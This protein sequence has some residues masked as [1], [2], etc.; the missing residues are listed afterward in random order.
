MIASV[1]NLRA[2]KRYVC[3]LIAASLLGG[4]C[5][6]FDQD[7]AYISASELTTRLVLDSPAVE[8]LLDRNDLI[9]G[10]DWP[11]HTDQ[12]R[13]QGYQYVEEHLEEFK[14]E[15]QVLLDTMAKQPGFT[16]EGRQSFRLL[17][18]SSVSCEPSGHSSSSIFI[19]VRVSTGPSKGMEGWTCTKD[20]APTGENVL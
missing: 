18:E 1:N 17:R 3:G 4:G 11:H 15:R 13:I 8:R 20:V 7:Y 16:V 12:E 2:S 10:K 14:A 19:L 9:A 5:R 6:A